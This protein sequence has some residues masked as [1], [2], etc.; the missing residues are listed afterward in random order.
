MMKRWHAESIV[1]RS[2]SNPD[3]P[4]ALLLTVSVAVILISL[5]LWLG[6]TP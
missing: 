1:G 4:A 2:W 5:A 6:S 3:P